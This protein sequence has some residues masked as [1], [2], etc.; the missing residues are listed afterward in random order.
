MRVCIATPAP[1]GTARGNRVTAD[2]WARFLRQQGHQVEISEDYGSAAAHGTKFDQLVALHAKRSHE[3]VVQFQAERPGRPVIVAL[4]GT[5][6]YRDLDTPEAQDSIA[7]ADRLITLQPLATD[8]LPASQ[9]S[10]AHVIFQSVEAPEGSFRKRKNTWEVLLVAN[11][12]DVK[13]PFLAPRAALALPAS[14]RVQIVHLG[15]VLSEELRPEL[16]EFQSHPDRYVWR[17]TLPHWKALR[18]MARCR[19]VVV[20][21]RLEGGPNCLSEAIAVGVPALATE[22]PGNVGLLG[23]GYPGYFPAGDTAALTEL[24]ERAENDEAFIEAL[25][26]GVAERR[27]FVN[28]ERE[29]QAWIELLEA[30]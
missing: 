12:R 27:K 20:T 30:L 29:R 24:L 13:D 8:E 26:E 11:I 18:L 2:R 16:E 3:S 21:S 1:P 15:E 22:I 7:R 9:R 17:E 23:E 14:S 28:P 6:I 4:T 19:L 25:T 10:K 5:D